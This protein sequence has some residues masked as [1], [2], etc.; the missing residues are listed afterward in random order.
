M[1][2]SV[3]R[4]SHLALAISSFLL[5]TV[6]S[7][8]GIFLAFEPVIEKAKSYKAE[9]FDTVTLAQSVPLLKEKFPG[10]QEISVD[11]NDFVVI[12]YAEEEGG[13]KHA[14][15]DPGTGKIL[16]TPK[17]KAPLF[18][19]MTVMHRSLFMK[20]TG[21][22]L[23]GITSFLLI[24]IAISG[25]LLIVQRQNGWRH[26]FSNI[27]KTGFAQYYHAV[28]GRLSLFFILAIALTGTYI[29]VYRF[30]PPPVK[31]S[32]AIKEETI[33][34]E[35]EI[36]LSNFAIF[37]QTPLSKLQKLQYPF[38]DF[39]EDYYNVQLEDKE[40][41]INQF[42]GEV[43]AEVSY[44]KTYQLANFSMRWH[45]GRSGS[46]WAIIMAIN[47]VYILFFIYSGFAIM[48]QRRRTRSKN[49]F[50][51]K[52]A[53]IVILAG[54]ENGGTFKFADAIYSQ[55]IQH[56]EK[57]FLTDLSNFTTFPNA[58]HLVV[59]T[60]TYGQGDPPSNAK[61]LSE[62]IKQHQQGQ[63]IQYSIVGFGSRSYTHFCKYAY[64]V[65]AMLQ[66][67][68]WALAIMPVYTVNDKSPQDFGAWLT[69]WTR[70]TGFKMMMPRE[71]LEPYLNEL[72]KLSVVT[73]T[74]PDAEAA[75][76]IRF[77]S[78]QLKH[79]VSGDLLAIY[80][81]NDHRERLYSIGKVNKE[82]QLSVKVHEH[83]LGSGFLNALK[84]GDKLQGKLIKNQHFR[85][86][87]N[88]KKIIMVANGT[89]IAPFLGMISENRK[90]VPVEL[91]CGFRNRSS[92]TLYQPF[93]EEQAAKGQLS[94]LHLVLSRE[95][96]KE[97]VSH[98]ILRNSDTVWQALKTGGVIMI[99]GSLSMQQDVMEVLADICTVE[100]S[101]NL[102][103]F[104]EQGKILTDCY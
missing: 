56:G 23:I 62:K 14:Y 100:N 20:E 53:R 4:Y 12:K 92:F 102:A 34:E 35:P 19:W 3:W 30:V 8:T 82:I 27:E 51:A 103:E 81:K 46:V 63:N 29:A 72:K 61:K 49:K 57:V 1:I 39:P 88:A 90:K 73:R 101:M 79:A 99:C 71:L 47:C 69:E 26:F 95:E 98:R 32:S 40:V 17:E 24:L 10:I 86:P 45:T 44:T 6:A 80:P 104:L 96:E 54:S 78:R 38:S 15:I 97:Y 68:A 85:F 36:G 16:G 94:Q 55:L 89:G 33:K 37:Q 22:I 66:T 31:A 65:E 7:V 21:R 83:G 84:N 11:D 2:I 13:D 77:R 50:K 52:D 74:A 48:L 67:N 87:K 70:L 42:T 60:S 75:F 9:G 28:F 25:V 43:L 91:Y 64:E 18:Q 41:C 76:T 59:M 93:L 5:L 58:E